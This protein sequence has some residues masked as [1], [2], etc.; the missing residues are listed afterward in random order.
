[1]PRRTL[2]VP[3]ISVQQP[4]QNSSPQAGLSPTS[5]RACS[6]PSKLEKMRATP[7]IASPGGSSG[8]SGVHAGLLGDRENRLRE[9]LVVRP[10]VL[11]RELAAE[12]GREVTREVAVDGGHDRPAAPDLRSGAVE[13]V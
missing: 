9:I 3:L 11:G 1:M 5:R 13:R 10:H 7:P 8:W 12:G 4:T 6:N 2:S